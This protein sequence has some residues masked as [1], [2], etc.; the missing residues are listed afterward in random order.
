MT[1]GLILLAG[2]LSIF[3]SSKV[4]YLTNEKTARLQENGRVALDLS[5]A[6]RAFRRLPGLLR[7]PKCVYFHAEWSTRRP[8]VELL[9]PAAGFRVRRG[10]HL[11]ARDR[12]RRRC[13]ES[14]TR[15]QQRRR[16]RAQLL[17]DGLALGLEA[18]V[19]PHR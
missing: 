7:A 1:I 14:R 3:L 8:V 18:N 17:R 11:V 2:V 6:R 4:T 12:G 16:R 15:E 19:G 13:A 5:H 9:D 10:R